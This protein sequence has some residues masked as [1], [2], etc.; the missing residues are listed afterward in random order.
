MDLG[1]I[2]MGLL[3]IIESVVNTLWGV[4]EGAFQG[5]G[6]ILNTAGILID[7]LSQLMGV[8]PKIFDIFKSFFHYIILF[9][10]NFDVVLIITE[11]FL[12]GIVIQKHRH[13]PLDAGKYFFIYNFMIVNYIYKFMLEF[14]R[15][16]FNTLKGLGSIIPGT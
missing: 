3:D 15:L 14:F 6:G 12:I 9:F 7:F 2:G 10:T 8:F 11:I 1:D 4:K 13:H 16:V 5:A